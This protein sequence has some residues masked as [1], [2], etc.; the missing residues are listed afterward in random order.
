MPTEFAIHK[1][2][3]VWCKDEIASY[4][5]DTVLGTAFAETID[6]IL[7]D[8][9]RPVSVKAAMDMLRKAMSEDAQYAWTWHCALAM[10]AFDE[11]VDHATSNKIAQRFM[12]LCFGVETSEPKSPL[13]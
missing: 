2:A 5:M 8:Q 9:D 13:T 1:A 4:E 3:Q 7:E 12:K 6:E 11:G 10:A